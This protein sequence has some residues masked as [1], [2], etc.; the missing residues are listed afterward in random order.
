MTN[1]PCILTIAGSDSGGGAGIQAD[2]KTISMQGCF[3]MSVITALTAQNSRGVTGI[4]APEP[5]FV[6]LQLKTVLDD[7]PVAAAKTGMLFSSGIIEAVADVLASKDFPLVVDPVC[8]SQSG[9]RLLQEDAVEALKAR[10]IPLA[11]LL[12]PNRPEAELLAGIPINTPDD[13][14]RAIKRLLEMGAGAVLLKGG[15]FE[16]GE[17]ADGQMADWLGVSGAEPIVMPQRMVHTNHTH[18]TGCTLSAAIASGLGLGLELRDA[19]VSGQEYLNLGLRAGFGPGSGY[20]PP[21]HLAPLLRA[22]KERS[23]LAELETAAKELSRAEGMNSLVPESGLNIAQ[24]LPW[25]VEA[26]DVAAFEGAIVA[27]SSGRL[28]IP[29]GA[30]FGV[31]PELANVLLGVMEGNQEVRCACIVGVD[32]V[33]FA[34]MREEG[35]G[36]HEAACIG[37]VVPEGFAGALP[38][39]LSEVGVA[40]VVCLDGALDRKARAVVLGTD[41]LDVVS[42]CI[43]VATRLKR[44][45]QA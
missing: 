8:V 11:D 30:A 33:V 5:D 42:K 21:N 7:F 39:A 35:L 19:V 38:H 17:L 3:G 20:G 22:R 4:H 44:R 37:E 34:A 43:R 29:G 41:A 27:A 28:M 18:G 23:V 6:A 36:V 24:A 32:S 40:D 14:Q 25:S 26:S 10:M 31:A 9:H 2:L 1:L 15:H 16:K 45:F 13:A 12:T